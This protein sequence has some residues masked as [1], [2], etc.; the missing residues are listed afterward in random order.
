MPPTWPP[1]GAP[2]SSPPPS[3]SVNQLVTL[4]DAECL[5]LLRTGPLGRV[6]VCF[7]ALP[8]VFPVH[9]RLLGRDPVFRTDAGTKLFAASA[10]HVLCLEADAVDPR[11]RTGWSVMVT[12]VASVLDGDDLVRAR[13]L[14]LDPWVGH[15]D[16]YVRVE[17]AL[18]SGRR[19]RPAVAAVASPS[20]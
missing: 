9:F 7:G 8:A 19:V 17:A 3:P 5:D 12:G 6:A 13:A 20:P 18:V 10:G 11:T 16:A 4:D 1:P 2:R 15:G 14:D